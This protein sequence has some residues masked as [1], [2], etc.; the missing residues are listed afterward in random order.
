MATINSLKDKTFSELLIGSHVAMKAPDYL[1]GSIQEMVGQHATAGMV[2]LGPPRNTSPCVVDKLKAAE[3]QKM[4]KEKKIDFK[5][6]SV[7]FRYI[8]NPSNPDSEKRAFAASFF[9][10]ELSAMEQ[11]GLTTCCFHPGSSKGANRYR[12]MQSC[13]EALGPIFAKH[14]HIHIGIETMA[15]KG[16]EV[17]V[18]LME[19]KL[20]L[21]YFHHL[22]NLGL[23]IDTCHL[24]DSGFDLTDTKAFEQSIKETIGFDRVFLIH[25]ND[26]LFPRGSHKDRHAN[27]GKG[28][29]GFKALANIAFLP[30]LKNVCKILETPQKEHEHQEEID[31]LR[32]C[33]L[34]Y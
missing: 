7:H 13:A 19:S 15:G 5:N 27:L 12:A 18:G 8:L 1:L 4:A 20:F 17:N 21:G 28:Y 9:D 25:L 10:K 32:A 33:F 23:C 26:S 11:L 16:D 29:I 6:I 34:G 14:P 2:F 24:W 3:A 22:E 30:S 31:K